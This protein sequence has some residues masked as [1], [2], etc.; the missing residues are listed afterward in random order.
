[1]L[2]TRNANAEGAD[3]RK[4]HMAATE[5]SDSELCWVNIIQLCCEKSVVVEDSLDHYDENT[6]FQK[7]AG[8]LSSPTERV[9]LK[10]NLVR[11]PKCF[12]F[13]THFIRCYDMLWGVDRW[14]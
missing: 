6:A 1:M 13:S 2:A 14:V 3:I 12:L 11:I 8:L 10:G 9:I 4:S 5:A 7:N